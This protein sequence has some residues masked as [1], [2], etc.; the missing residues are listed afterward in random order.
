MIRTDKLIVDGDKV[1]LL[2]P[3]GSSLVSQ[4]HAKKATVKQVD[5]KLLNVEGRSDLD[6][7]VL[8]N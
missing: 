8:V 3:S 6:F 7:H 1:H 5:L 2:K 4:T